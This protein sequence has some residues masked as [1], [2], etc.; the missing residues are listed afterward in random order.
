MLG[1]LLLPAAARSQIIIA[2]NHFDASAE[3]WI[4]VK[5]P[6]FI[7]TPAASTTWQAMG[8][9]PDGYLRHLDP[10]DGEISYWSAPRVLT[11]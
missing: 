11:R 6:N 2:E 4:V 1:L 9:N 5:T 7:P 10:S 8:G 3:G